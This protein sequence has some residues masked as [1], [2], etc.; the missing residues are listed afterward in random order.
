MMWLMWNQMIMHI[1]PGREGEGDQSF[2]V[3]DNGIVAAERDFGWV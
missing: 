2:R 3:C 1:I